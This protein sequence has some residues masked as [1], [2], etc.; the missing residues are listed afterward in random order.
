MKFGDKIQE[1]KFMTRNK[2]GQNTLN[3]LLNR[4]RREVSYLKSV[5]ITEARSKKYKHC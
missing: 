4:K 3:A 1:R 2:D 5:F